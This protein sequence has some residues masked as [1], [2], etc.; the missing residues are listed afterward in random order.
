MT[1]RRFKDKKE[2]VGHH[3]FSLYNSALDGLGTNKN[4]IPTLCY[5]MS[6]AQHTAKASGI[7]IPVPRIVQIQLYGIAKRFLCIM[8]RL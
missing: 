1:R 5:I 3:S 4:S 8:L 2:S 6:M 7:A